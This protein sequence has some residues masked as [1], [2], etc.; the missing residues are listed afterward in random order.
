VT[1]R[2]SLGARNAVEVAV[3][4]RGSGLAEEDVERLFEPF[5]T[6]KAGGMGLGL[7]IS[8]WIVEAHGGR[9]EAAPGARQGTTFRFTLPVEG[10]GGQR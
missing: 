6:R 1:I 7:S 8:R 5:Y 3:D 4:D 2:T 9:L 10:E